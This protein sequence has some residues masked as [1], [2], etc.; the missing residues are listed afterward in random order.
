[1]AARPVTRR[2]AKDVV[3]LP[4]EGCLKLDGVERSGQH[5]D[6]WFQKRKI[7]NVCSSAEGTLA[8]TCK[9]LFANW[10][11]CAPF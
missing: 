2:M 10:I 6:A 1:M 7:N 5:V 3:S 4:H 8:Q 11:I 9:G